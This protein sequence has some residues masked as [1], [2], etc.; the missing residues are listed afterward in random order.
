MD[1]QMDMECEGP[2][3]R[4]GICQSLQSRALSLDVVCD[5]IDQHFA[6]EIFH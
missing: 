4:E 2:M 5:Q 6:N 1:I 3:T